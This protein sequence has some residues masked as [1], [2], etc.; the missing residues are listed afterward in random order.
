METTQEEF[1]GR[2]AKRCYAV[3]FVNFNRFCCLVMGCKEDVHELF[4]SCDQLVV[5]I[6][7]PPAVRLVQIVVDCSDELQLPSDAILSA[8]LFEDQVPQIP[9]DLFAS[10][11]QRIGYL[12]QQLDKYVVIMRRA[13]S[14]RS[15]QMT[16]LEDEEY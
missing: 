16:T 8:L 13:W 1:V 7:K 5:A 11:V 4:V 14:V 10:V 2:F 9:G 6:E 15:L 3:V 12:L